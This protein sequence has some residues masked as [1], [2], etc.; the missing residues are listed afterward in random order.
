MTC[1]FSFSIFAIWKKLVNSLLATLPKVAF[2]FFWFRLQIRRITK[3]NVIKKWSKTSLLTCPFIR[4]RG[5]F[6]RLEATWL[7][8][9]TKFQIFT[10]FFLLSYMEK[11]TCVG[12]YLS[13]VPFSFI[14]ALNPLEGQISSKLFSFVRTTV[15]VVIRWV[16]FSSFFW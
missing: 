13:L 10:D 7:T 2:C 14:A 1:C 3:N 12:S 11:M 8:L 9:Q 5:P 16:N 15:L 4:N 6:K